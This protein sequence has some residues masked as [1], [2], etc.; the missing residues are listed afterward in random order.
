MNLGECY[1]SADLN[2]HLI[3]SSP[4]SWCWDSMSN[5]HHIVHLGSRT[6]DTSGVPCIHEAATLGWLPPVSILFTSIV[7]RVCS[8]KPPQHYC[9]SQAHCHIL[10]S[11]SPGRVGVNGV[12]FFITYVYVYAHIQVFGKGTGILYSVDP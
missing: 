5:L 7:H 4:Q 8:E 12:L 1:Y 10:E 2:F 3:L 9:P 11:A 6:Q